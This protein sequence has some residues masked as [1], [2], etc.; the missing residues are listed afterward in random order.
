MALVSSALAALDVPTLRL[1][2]VRVS[3]WT[4]TI[5]GCKPTA[6]A[7]ANQPAVAKFLGCSARAIAAVRGAPFAPRRRR[8]SAR[9]ERRVAVCCLR[10]DTLPFE[11]LPYRVTRPRLSFPLLSLQPFLP[12]RPLYLPS[13]PHRSAMSLALAD[14][15]PIPV[16]RG[17]HAFYAK[18]TTQVVMVALCCF[19]CPGPSRVSPL[20]LQPRL[21]PPHALPGMF[22][23]VNGLGGGGQVDADPANKGNIALNCTFAVTSFFSGTSAFLRGRVAARD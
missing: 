20:A 12:S 7:S 17:V 15:R 13:A 11:R 8:R 3:C 16:R 23:A 14:Q 10:G 6:K 4:A 9:R 5:I 21:T 19:A 18:P 22:N 2:R 1:C